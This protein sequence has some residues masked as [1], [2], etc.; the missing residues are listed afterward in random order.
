MLDRG[1]EV[2]IAT[3]QQPSH[4][5]RTMSVTMAVSMPFSVVQFMLTT[6]HGQLATGV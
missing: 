2:A 4:A 3:F 6:Q 1:H 5:G